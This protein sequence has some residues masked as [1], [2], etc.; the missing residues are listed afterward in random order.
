MINF[1]KMHGNGNDFIVYN[2]IESNKK[3]SKSK[4]QK[5]SNRNSGIGFDQA[6]QIG[7]PKKDNIDFSIRFFNA[8]GGEAS[9]CLNGIRCAASYVWQNNFA[10]KKS[11][12]FKTKNIEINNLILNDVDKELLSKLYL[13]S[14]FL[15]QSASLK[16]PH[17][18]ANYLYEVSNLFNQFYESEKILEIED[19][20]H[21]SSKMYIT[22]LFLTT[23]QN[24]MWCLGIT[25]VNRM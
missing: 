19:S 15:E 9:M 17:H 5:L 6:I 11:I 3:L 20:D 21:L 14:Y 23:S 13:F 7:L 2:I 10:P 8:D 1:D 24:V 12:I 18:L 4:I 16:E 25:P 22:N